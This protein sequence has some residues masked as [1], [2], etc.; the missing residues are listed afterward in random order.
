[1]NDLKCKHLCT[2]SIDR[3]IELWSDNSNGTPAILLVKSTTITASNEMLHHW[4]SYEHCDECNRMLLWPWPKLEN[5]KIQINETDT[6]R[7]LCRAQKHS[8]K[9]THI[10][11]TAFVWFSSVLFGS[12]HGCSIWTFMLVLQQNQNLHTWIT[13]TVVSARLHNCNLILC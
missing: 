12:V 9:W 13:L 5:A 4:H 2:I 8:E 10:M 1:M 11:R 3:S 7:L 6:I